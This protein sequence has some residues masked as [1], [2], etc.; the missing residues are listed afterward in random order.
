M[1]FTFAAATAAESGAL[2][3]GAT[4]GPELLAAAARADRASRGAIGR[5]LAA[6]RFKGKP[7]QMVQILAPAGLKVSQIIVA[8]L[9]KAEEFD[10]SAAENLAA[11]ALVRLKGSAETEVVF[12]LDGL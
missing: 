9:G 10:A 7:G 4:E 8:G 1:Q 3:V 6:S 11:S 2:V 12:N 5:A